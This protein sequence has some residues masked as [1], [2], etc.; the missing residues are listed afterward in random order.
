MKNC[1]ILF[2]VLFVFPL[3][4]SSQTL[5][6]K[7]AEID[8]YAATVTDT[9]KDKSGAGMAIAVI[10]DD[11]V[12]MQ[13]GYGVRELGKPERPDENTVFAIASNSK[14]FTTAAI[15]IL[16][17]E[18]KLAWDDRCRNTYLISRCTTRG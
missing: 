14:A 16:V 1:K 8:A 18:K 7:L 5:D 9:W 17:D 2:L 3:I 15:A 13:K 4:A 6:E 11:K 12:V 10:K